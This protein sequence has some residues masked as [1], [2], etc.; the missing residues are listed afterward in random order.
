MADSNQFF[1]ETKKEIESYLENRALLL[2]MQVIDKTARLGAKLVLGMTLGVLGFCLVFFLSIMAGYFFA[3]LTGSLYIGFGI[4]V[5]G[6]FL[7]ILLV[8]WNRKSIGNSI[9][10]TIIQI[11]FD[12]DE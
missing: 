11:L 7:L 9:A 6:Y 8:Y 2:K 12:K 10:N 1:S 5:F 3:D 4:V